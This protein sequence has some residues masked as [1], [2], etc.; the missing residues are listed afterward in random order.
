MHSQEPEALDKAIRW[1]TPAAWNADPGPGTARNITRWIYAWRRALGREYRVWSTA[2]ARVN[3]AHLRARGE[4]GRDPMWN[5]G[6][7]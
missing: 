5:P 7:T 6:T 2:H 3:P 1:V 4:D